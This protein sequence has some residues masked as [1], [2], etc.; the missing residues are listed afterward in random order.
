MAKKKENPSSYFA[1]MSENIAV[2]AEQTRVQTKILDRMENRQDRI[3]EGLVGHDVKTQE[4]NKSIFRTLTN[5]FRLILTL[6]GALAGLVGI[7]LYL[8]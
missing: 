5:Y 2:I 1:Q 8:Q 3:S 4:Q 6:I 7:K